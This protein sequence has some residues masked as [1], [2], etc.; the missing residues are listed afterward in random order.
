MKRM[1]KRL[2]GWSFVLLLVAALVYALRPTP[3]PADFAPVVRGSLRVT[4]DEEGET[5]VRNRFI[6]SAPLNGRV[7]RIE[8]DPGDAEL[9]RYVGEELDR[10]RQRARL[11]PGVFNLLPAHVWEALACACATAFDAAR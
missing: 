3:A 4:V 1:L 11:A 7:L 9:G 6:I 2:A 8:L 5:R 10:N